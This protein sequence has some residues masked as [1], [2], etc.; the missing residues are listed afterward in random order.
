MTRPRGRF[1]LS[2]LLPFALALAVLAAGDVTPRASQLHRAALVVDL[3]IDTPQRLLDEEF[4]LGAR[5]THGHADIPRMKAG[6][7]DAGFMS[8]YVDMRRYEGEA[9]TKRALQLID[10][11][12][13]QA[14]R[15]PNELMLATTAADIRR[16]HEEGKIALLMGMEGGTPI[17]DDLHLLRDFH[18][19]GV[20]YMTL[21][22]SL[23]NNWADSS[24]DEPRHNGLTEFGRDVVREMNRLGMLVDIS[25]VS[26]KAFYDTLEVTQAPVIASHS[27][28]R[29][30]CDV[31]RNMSDDMIRAL[32]KNGGVIHINYHIGFLDQNF[33]DAYRHV[34][35]EFR[36]RDRAL[37]E[38][39]KDNPKGLLA[40][41][42]ES[43]RE[44]RAQLPRV[45]WERILEHIDYVVKLVG[46]DH[47]GLGSDF[48]G[49]WMPEG[50]DDTSHLPR[51]TQALLDRGYSEADIKKILGGNTL[52]VT[53]EA[54]RVASRL[55][56]P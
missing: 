34:A 23:N 44:L 16:A 20:R 3:H 52:R 46:V 11:V 51:L 50:M 1:L 43:E 25:H 29:A 55:R 15:H 28:A 7:L 6:G 26:D 49:A 36:A 5:D 14:E 53:E 31:S 56:R 17:A 2:A 32:A 13:Q 8:I 33:A 4:D 42:E 18:R 19:L 24:T 39:Y 41:R 45:S 30:L 10:T 9:A 35:G 38:Q 27:S 47:V 12:Y 48:D 54:E 37:E 40:A 21:T 22:H